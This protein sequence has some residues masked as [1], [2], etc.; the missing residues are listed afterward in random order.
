MNFSYIPKDR[1][2]EA[3]QDCISYGLHLFI[4]MRQQ[5]FTTF[6]IIIQHRDTLDYLWLIIVHSRFH[7]VAVYCYLVLC[8][9]RDKKLYTHSF[10]LGTNEG[11]T[12]S[13]TSRFHS[14]ISH[15]IEY[16][17][18]VKSLKEFLNTALPSKFMAVLLNF[19]PIPRYLS[20][21]IL[22]LNDV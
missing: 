7:K 1:K 16:I 5:S 8:L 20:K 9:D 4:F 18:I 6:L 14:F 11:I 22:F 12:R 3:V 10:L 2:F 19:R 17:E 21:K 13:A 15:S